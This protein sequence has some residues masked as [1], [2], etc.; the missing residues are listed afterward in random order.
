MFGKVSVAQ[1]PNRRCQQYYLFGDVCGPKFEWWL[2]HSFT[3]YWKNDAQLRLSPDFESLSSV[4]IMKDGKR[5][6]S[7][8]FAK[9]KDWAI[10]KKKDWA[11]V[12]S[13]FSDDVITN[14]N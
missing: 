7:F 3:I 12:A 6:L 8:S 14:P 10:A 11:I 2:L 4:I 13:N 9:K 5:N 1:V